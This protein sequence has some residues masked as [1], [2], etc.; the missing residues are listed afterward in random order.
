[1]ACHARW[2]R[3][4]TGR[5]TPGE[6]GAV[7]GD[8]AGNVARARCSGV[9]WGGGSALASGSLYCVSDLLMARCR[10]SPWPSAI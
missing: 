2:G 6:A 8:E 3:W 7:E 5:W 9:S 4:G 1:M 10:I